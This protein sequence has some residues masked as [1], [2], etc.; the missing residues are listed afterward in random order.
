MTEDNLRAGLHEALLTERLS[1][2]LSHLDL[3]RVDP[4]FSNLDVGS[5]S[6]RVSRHLA[7][8]IVS[9]IESGDGEER[10]GK[11]I[12][13]AEAIVRTLVDAGVDEDVLND[14]PLDP[15]RIL[16]AIRERNPDGSVKPIEA[17]L[18]PLLDTTVLTNAQGEPKVGHE[19]RAET[20]SAD[21]IDVVMAF[22]RWSGVRPLVEAIRRH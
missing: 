18:T 2:A 7:R 11:A 3:T 21:A 15:P 19:L 9:A 8:V 13:L 6:D 17:P 1:A 4:D 10:V 20:A 14:I 16:R 5:A 22:I 12:E